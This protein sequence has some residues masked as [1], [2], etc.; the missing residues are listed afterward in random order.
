MENQK[1]NYYNNYVSV[2]Y[3]YH[4]SLSRRKFS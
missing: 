2:E 4:K 1:H 3:T